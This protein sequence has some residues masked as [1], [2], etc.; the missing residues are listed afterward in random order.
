MR[1]KEI[2][3]PHQ[4]HQAAK[5]DVLKPK[6]RI[7]I[8]G[9]KASGKTCMIT[10]L[11][12]PRDPHPAGI[13]ATIPAL[14]KG[15]DEETL[16][17]WRWISNAVE[18]LNK[19]EWPEAN[20]VDDEWLKVLVEFTRRRNEGENEGVSRIIELHD[21]S[22]ELL[23]PKLASEQVA[24]RI[25]DM[26]TEM[27]GWIVLA[28]YPRSEIEQS[29]LEESLHLFKQTLSKLEG[30]RRRHRG[31]PCAFVVN[32]WDRSPYY[33]PDATSEEQSA[34]IRE[35]YFK[36][37]PAPIHLDLASKIENANRG[38]FKCFA[39][40]A[41]GQIT[42]EHD[43]DQVPEG[44][45]LHSRG[46]EDPFWWIIN[47]REK[48]LKERRS[49]RAKLALVSLVVVLICGLV[50]EWFI[51]KHW[52]A[53]AEDRI[54]S[55]VSKDWRN[56]VEWYRTYGGSPWWR[57]VLY[58]Q[59]PLRKDL[60]FERARSVEDES[61][62]GNWKAIPVVTGNEGVST[63][64]VIERLL[65]EHLE[66]FANSNHKENATAMLAEI[67]QRKCEI[68]F[69][70]KLAGWQSRLEQIEEEALGAEEALDSLQNLER[71][72][73]DCEG[74][75]L[76]G[77]L[78]KQWEEL[79]NAIDGKRSEFQGE[80]IADKEFGEIKALMVT[81]KYADSADKLQNSEYLHPEL[82]GE[83][84][85]GVGSAIDREAVRICKNGEQWRAAVERIDSILVPKYR[86]LMSD[87]ARGRLVNAI[88]RCKRE[89]DS[90][91]YK[92]VV[93]NRDDV[94]IDSYL[95]EA[96]LRTMSTDV[97][98]YKHWLEERK[99]PRDI[100]IKLV[101]IE[102][103]KFVKGKNTVLKLYVNSKGDSRNEKVLKDLQ[104][105][106]T[107][108]G[109]EF[110]R[111]VQI[112]TPQSKDVKVILQVW[113]R[114]PLIGKS[115]LKGRIEINKTPEELAR[116]GIF[117]GMDDRGNRV[118]LVV[119]GVLKEPVLPKWRLTPR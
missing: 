5:L 96:P 10:A 31:R 103:S 95:A 108:G 85:R 30:P 99:N 102:W 61:M 36:E 106:G 97:E 45:R 43:H 18:F 26:L 79:I 66:D 37:K 107:S 24:Q 15:A 63:L 12:M 13:T 72:L 68:D 117:R 91:L 76:Q 50:S 111:E 77:N 71:E 46:L 110:W 59:H 42:V 62:E 27:D 56:G 64:D 101:Q 48:F 78:L 86:V 90:Y 53:E 65:C 20:P 32:K 9:P 57:H 16:K 82:R 22:G 58:S 119:Y 3:R 39:V 88:D 6:Y 25:H 70:R 41:M 47:Q 98:K 83:W 81:G 115:E 1:T 73:L 21:Y 67:E 4:K 116:D 35:S 100:I 33:N 80:L 74:I 8:V 114:P 19:G 40:S 34:L 23:D 94:P 17:G 93:A 75:P 118:Q 14:G 38:P 87:T 92:L 29:N 11:H 60:A 28:E 89:G 52:R 84:K 51:D 69:K 2:I 112:Q 104:R 113:E 105:V 7:G 44:G 54:Q 55:S 109:G 49:R